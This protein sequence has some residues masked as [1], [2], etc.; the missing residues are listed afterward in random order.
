MSH[1]AF[2]VIFLCEVSL[3]G[4]FKNTLNIFVE[5]KHQKSHK[6]K[7]STHPP[8]WAGFFFVPLATPSGFTKKSINDKKHK[9][10]KINIQCSSIFCFVACYPRFAFWVVSQR[11]AP[12]GVQEHH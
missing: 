9:H 2:A 12:S 11:V 6:K 1:V 7:T 3:H 10:K 8:P 5:K 4:V